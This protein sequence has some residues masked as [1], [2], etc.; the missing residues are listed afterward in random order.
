MTT[1][2][3]LTFIA[4]WT[5]VTAAAVLCV[6]ALLVVRDL[7]AKSERNRSVG[8]ATGYAVVEQ[9]VTRVTSDPT[10]SYLIPATD[11][12]LP[13]AAPGSGR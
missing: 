1:D 11:T 6:L 4:T 2:G 7:A 5:Y 9:S 8:R 12:T 10:R 3:R 13:E